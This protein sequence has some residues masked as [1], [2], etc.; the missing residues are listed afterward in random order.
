MKRLTQILVSI[1]G[2]CIAAVTP[3]AADTLDNIR[4]RGHLL[5]G[6]HQGKPGFAL[7]DASGAWKGFDIDFCRAL[8]AAIFDDPQKIGS[9]PL[10]AKDRFTAVQSGEVDVLYRVSSVTSSRETALGLSSPVINYYDGQG[11]I[12]KKALNVK[13]C[14]ELN[15]VS[16]CVQQGTT[17]ESNASDWFRK[18][19]LKFRLIAF[20]TLD[21]AINSYQAGRCDVFTDDLSGLA[22]LRLKL[23]APDERL[24]PCPTWCRK[25]RSDRSCARAT[26]SGI[27]SCDGSIS[28]W[29][30]PKSSTLRRRICDEAMRSGPPEARRLLGQEGS[31]GQQLGLTNDWAYRVIRHVGNYGESFA[32]NLGSESPL[33]IARGLND[34]WTRGGLQYALPVR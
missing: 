9:V 29:C 33:K 6:T 20:A 11:F 5:C 25:N 2:L 14:G 27:A 10:T 23:T 1:L 26:T 17:T 24:V 28:R 16:V 19:G 32:R 18:N 12:V 7:P 4:T 3:S 31:A 13:P 30:S 8:A 21:E 15:D 22:T 34:L